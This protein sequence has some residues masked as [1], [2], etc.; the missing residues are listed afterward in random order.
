MAEFTMNPIGP[1]EAGERVVFNTGLSTLGN[2]GDDYLCGHCGR[3][4]ITNMNLARLEVEVVYACGGCGG[5][6]LPPSQ[7]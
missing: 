3:Q 7:G 1:D 2:G 5:H 4:M 6:N